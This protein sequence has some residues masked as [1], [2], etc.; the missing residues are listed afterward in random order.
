MLKRANYAFANIL[1]PTC[2]PSKI[3]K[4]KKKTIKN[5]KLFLNAFQVRPVVGGGVLICFFTCLRNTEAVSQKA[6][7]CPDSLPCSD[8]SPAA[9]VGFNCLSWQRGQ[10]TVREGGATGSQTKSDLKKKYMKFLLGEE[11][12]SKVF[13]QFHGSGVKSHKTP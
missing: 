3:K 6:H 2:L 4:K 11:S 7:F 9:G 8:Q 1:S 5:F 12:N 13:I 10:L